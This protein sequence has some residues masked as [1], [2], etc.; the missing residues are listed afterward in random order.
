MMGRF[1]VKGGAASVRVEGENW[2]VALGASLP[3]FGLDS[4]SLSHLAVDVAPSG[5]VTV[6]DPVTGRTFELVPLADEPLATAHL[7]IALDPKAPPRPR[8]PAA[9]MPILPPMSF[10]VPLSLPAAEQPRPTVQAAPPMFVVPSARVMPAEPELVPEPTHPTAVPEELAPPAPQPA[11][12][13]GLAPPPV[14]AAPPPEP[15]PAREPAPEPSSVETQVMPASLAPPPQLNPGARPDS[16]A[17]EPP[18]P[19]PPPPVLPKASFV[20]DGRPAALVEDLFDACFELSFEPDIGG[21]CRKA[22]AILSAVVPAEAGAVLY[23]GLN[24]RELSFSAAF[25]PAAG[26][27]RGRTLPLDTGIAGFVHQRG[28]NLVISDAHADDRHDR[29]VDQAS[30]YVTGSI[31]AASVRDDQGSSFGCIELLNPPGGFRDWHLEAA[32]IVARALAQ[33][34]GSRQE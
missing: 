28:I 23:G 15:G 16:A 30:G 9:A 17:V 3:H 12:P 31:L 21:A 7:G 26:A 32:M 4:S 1:E 19:P 11:L 8:A 22:L 5:V 20:E 24:S 34:V 33:F 2:L 10:G 14:L 25:G 18:T 29:S 6:R 27:L 13:P